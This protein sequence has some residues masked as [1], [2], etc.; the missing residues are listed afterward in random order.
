MEPQYEYRNK[1]SEC[2][3]LASK[4]DPGADGTWNKFLG[5]AML[6]LCLAEASEKSNRFDTP[7]RDRN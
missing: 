5:M 4:T 1:A 3:D 2:L 7:G 6:W